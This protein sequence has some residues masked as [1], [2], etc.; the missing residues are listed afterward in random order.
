MILNA[1]AENGSLSA[2]LRVITSPLS[3]IDAFDL[4]GIERRGQ[5]IHHR[6]EQR[7]HAFVL[8]GSADHHRKNFQSDGRLAQ[9][10][11]QFG[12]RNGLAFEELVQHLVVVFGDGFDQLRCGRLRLSSAVRRESRR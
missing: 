6:I 10:S 7:L 9:R 2:G 8:E 4:A 11:P 12:G 3:G 1:S 5:I